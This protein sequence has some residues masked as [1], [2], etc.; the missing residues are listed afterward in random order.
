M[1]INELLDMPVQI[2]N[3]TYEHTYGLGWLLEKIGMV[4]F[5]LW[6]SDLLRQPMEG[7]V[8][9]GKYVLN[10]LG[11]SSWPLTVRTKE[12]VIVLDK[13]TPE[14]IIRYAEYLQYDDDGLRG[15]VHYAMKV[16]TV[17]VST[18]GVCYVHSVAVCMLCG[19]EE[20]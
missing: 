20:Y 10:C 15:Q 14:D 12:H 17:E 3:T 7:K 18:L 6:L 19:M 11:L 5:N 8:V 4:E 1:D 2:S 13:L 9:D 16:N